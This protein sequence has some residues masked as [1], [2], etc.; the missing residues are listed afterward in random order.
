MMCIAVERNG[1]RGNC[2]L[3]P[4]VPFLCVYVG[5]R[6]REREGRVCEKEI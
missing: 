5:E 4:G 1:K 6:E 2:I 3:P